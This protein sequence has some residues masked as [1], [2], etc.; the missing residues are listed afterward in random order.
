MGGKTSTST[1]QVQVPPDVLAR[2]N[3]VNATAQNVAST[4]FQQY[5]TSP[6]A[7]VAPINAEQTQGINQ[8][9]SFA[10]A[11]QPYIGA[12]TGYTLAGAN[13]VNAAPITASDINQ[14]ESPYLSTVLGSTAAL[15]NQ[16]NQKQQSGALGEA[17]QQGAF[18]GDRAGIAAA[19]LEQQQNLGNANIY[20]GIANTAFNT[21]LST[22]QQQ[23]G[24]NLGAEQANRAAV[25]QTGA[26][27][28]TLGTT[29]QTAGLQGAGAEQAAGAT[30][31][32]TTQAGDTA[33]YNQFLQQQSYP[34]QVAQFL[35]NIAEGTGALSGSTTTTT[36]PQSIFSDA[37]LK[38]DVEVI[39]KTF[40][41]QNVVAFRYKGDPTR[42]MGLIAQDVEKKHPEAVREVG[43][44]KAVDYDK[45]TAADAEKGHFYKGGLVPANDD[46]RD[47]ARHARAYGGT[48]L[49]DPQELAT[50]EAASMS[51]GAGTYGPYTSGGLYG[52]QASGAPRGGLSYVPSANLPVGRLSVAQPAPPPPSMLSQATQVANLGT[53]VSDAANSKTGQSVMKGIGNLFQSPA[54]QLAAGDSGPELPDFADL[55]SD[56]PFR[57]GGFARPHRDLGG[58]V[59]DDPYGPDA[60]PGTRGGLNIPDDSPK[61]LSLAVAKP[62]GQ[63]QSNTLG[64]VANIGADV[65]KLAAFLPF[66]RGGAIPDDLAEPQGDPADANLQAILRSLV[67]G[68]PGEDGNEDD[69]AVE[70]P[71]GASDA[72][73]AP[74]NLGAAFMGQ[75]PGSPPQAAPTDAAGPPG[76]TSSLPTDIAGTLK[77]IARAEGTGKNPMSSA[78]GPFQIID[79][80]FVG[81]YRQM[82]PEQAQGMSKAQILALRSTPQGDQLSAEMGPVLAQQNISKL[83]GAGFQPSAPNVYLAHF[84]GP[85]GAVRVLGADPS[86]PMAQLESPLA[87]SENASIMKGKTAGDVVSWAAR[88]LQQVSA[89]AA[90]GKVRRGFA[91]GGL[92]T[93]DSGNIVFDAPTEIDGEDAA[94][95]PRDGPVDPPLAEQAASQNARSVQPGNMLPM[96]LQHDPAAAPTQPKQGFMESL[97]KPEVFIPLL[98]GLAAAASTPTV[99]PLMAIAE[100]LGAGAQAYQGQREYQ[101]QQQQV[102]QHGQ[103][104]GVLQASQALEPQRIA[105]TQAEAAAHVMSAKAALV[106]NA[107]ATFRAQYVPAGQ[108]GPDGAPMYKDPYGRLISATDYGR[109]QYEYINSVL[110]NVGTA[111][112]NSGPAL[113]NPIGGPSGV[114]GGSHP[115]SGDGADIA[116]AALPPGGGAG[117]APGLGA[118][119]SQLAL[120]G[121]RGTQ[122]PAVHVSPAAPLA[123]KLRA[124]VYLGSPVALPSVDNG[125]LQQS[126]NPEYLKQQGLGLIQ[127][128]NPDQ[129]TLG[130]HLIDRA[131]AIT[132]GSIIP[133]DVSGKP[134][135]GYVAYNQALAQQNA[136]Q[137]SYAQAKVG[138]NQAASDFASQMPATF[139]LQN[140]LI[141]LYQDYNTNRLSPDLADLVGRA[142]SIP[143][144]SAL[145]QPA[146]HDYQ[147]ATDEATKQ[148][149]R[150]AIV[151]AVASHIASGAPASALSQANKT[152]PQPSMAPGARYALAAQQLALLK[153]EQDYY[154]DWNTNKGQVNDVSSYD[155]DWMKEHPIGGYEGWAYDHITPFKGMTPAEMA[156]HPRKPQGPADLAQY[157]PG[158]PYLIPDGPRKG[159]MAWR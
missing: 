86:T 53:K 79:P 153:L 158:T 130:Q 34:F 91:G 27:L 85:A 30:Q 4:P 56:V 83:Q 94:P 68:A 25:Q 119:G 159:Q 142:S 49:M 23:Q 36:Q 156:Q 39:G 105:A 75:S 128:G 127:T 71:P 18:G 135:N 6:D 16:N 152:V 132:S 157:P 137:Q 73:G 43:G 141:R 46:W 5:S 106:G 1:S 148:T 21:A 66:A 52:T 51:G 57:R 134:Y 15:L 28:A 33:L 89:R 107:L 12:A 146:W 41:G 139:Q 129:Q 77:L 19:N 88:R 2:Y 9:N 14:Y 124:G 90:G 82:F 149:A 54:Q 62:P 8:T 11:A 17:I 31:Q 59:D 136:V 45:A 123:A 10:D 24:V 122:A 67:K 154:H 103:E 65:A 95:G 150:Q 116:G 84:L 38:E 3:S 96:P 72:P 50:L 22:A 87:I 111:G 44:F 144:L 80:T 114:S 151:Q 109:A 101:L 143:G 121:D 100:G 110:G 76:P 81:L 145:V 92:S 140:S 155:A 78:K 48:T 147:S 125:Q 102:A 40:G 7:F 99:H 47:E 133:T 58:S 104:V 35:A 63:Q 97:K 131:S 74:M 118:S 29:A 115:T 112:L 70:A 64:D 55:G 108:I 69:G 20:S 60:G 13:P 42:R 93:D 98:T 113:P 117:V 126:D 32:Q 37:R 120:P 26:N 61:S 138:K